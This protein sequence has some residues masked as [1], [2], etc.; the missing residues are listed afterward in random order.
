MERKNAMK[1]FRDVLEKSGMNDLVSLS[2]TPNE[3]ADLMIY[4]KPNRPEYLACNG[5]PLFEFGEIS[6]IL[7]QYGE[8][9]WYNFVGTELQFI[10]ELQGDSS[11]TLEY[12]ENG[13]CDAMC[14][15]GV[16]ATKDEEIRKMLAQ[17]NHRV[18]DRCNVENLLDS[19]LKMIEGNENLMEEEQQEITREIKRYT[20]E[21]PWDKEFLFSAADGMVRAIVYE[22]ADLPMTR[23]LIK[24]IVCA[25]D[26]KEFME[27]IRREEGQYDDISGYDV[28]LA[29]A[30]LRLIREIKEEQKTE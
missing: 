19:V 8:E 22:E 13:F 7:Y 25:G 9:K 27:Y 10:I 20:E 18:S 29:T 12:G 14:L 2:E 15:D 21:N 28:G 23:D 30:V 4:Q 3:L 26:E 17:Y 1:I 5:K 16:W 6:N 11:Y 24:Q